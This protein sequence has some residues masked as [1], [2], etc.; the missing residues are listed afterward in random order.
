MFLP[1]HFGLAENVTVA[2]GQIDQQKR[3]INGRKYMS[4]LVMVFE[5]GEIRV[6]VNRVVC[7]K[8]FCQVAL[9]CHPT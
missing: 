5:R 8:C 9:L 2:W 1:S 6:E 4:T 3:N 7:P